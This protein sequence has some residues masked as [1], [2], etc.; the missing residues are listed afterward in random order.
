MCFLTSP[1]LLTRFDFSGLIFNSLI[2][3]GGGG[4]GAV[5]NSITN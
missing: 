2:G 5:I 4:G 3:N 1:P